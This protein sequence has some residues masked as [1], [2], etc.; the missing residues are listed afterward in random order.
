MGNEK[1]KLGPGAMTI[2]QEM[3]GHELF[4]FLFVFSFEYGHLLWRSKIQIVIHLI[5]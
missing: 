1:C 3:H 2:L 4:L 5:Q